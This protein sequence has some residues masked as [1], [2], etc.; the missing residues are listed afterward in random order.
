ME[1]TKI[2]LKGQYEDSQIRA[3]IPNLILTNEAQFPDSKVKT[4]NDFEI[5]DFKINRIEADK[6]E[7]DV[8]WKL[9]SFK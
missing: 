4:R 5:I 8:Y 6:L 2:S 1:T 7:V 3:L 9:K